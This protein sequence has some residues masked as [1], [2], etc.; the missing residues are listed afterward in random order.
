M[1]K[2]HSWTKPNIPNIIGRKKVDWSL[3]QWGSTIPL[4]FHDAFK[5]VGFPITTDNLPSYEIKLIN[6]G[7]QYRARL[8]KSSITSRN[9]LTYQIRFDKDP[10]FCKIIERTFTTSFN[11]INAERERQKA[12]GKL[13]PQ[14]VIP[15]ER[16]EYIDFLYSDSLNEIKVIF[17]T[18]PDEDEADLQ[19]QQSIFKELI[20]INLLI[21]DIPKPLQQ[22]RESNSVTFPRDPSLGRKAVEFA[23]YSCEYDLTHEHFIS[24]RTNR[25]YVE[26]HHLI[27]LE[28]QSLFTTSSLDV[29]SNIVSLCC[30]CH[31]KLHHAPLSEKKEII[32]KLYRDRILRLQKCNLDISID[33]LF[34][35]YH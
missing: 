24:K 32:D 10:E 20:P 4:E 33:Q 21:H 30:L 29:E 22:M 13:R 34:S 31:K 1:A 2:D 12:L 19:Y 8:Q 25:N 28:F 15:N 6:G 9:N 11:F 18:L 7:R 26:A 17:H 35:F 14:V 5:R 16:A 23:N 3:S 27:P